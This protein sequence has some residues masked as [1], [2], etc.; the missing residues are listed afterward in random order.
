MCP[1]KIH[2]GTPE[3]PNVGIVLQFSETQQLLASVGELDLTECVVA[4]T[5][6]TRRVKNGDLSDQEAIL[7]AQVVALNAIFTQ[8]AH[9]T[10]QTNRRNVEHV[11]PQRS[12]AGTHWERATGPRSA[13]GKARSARNAYR[14]GYRQTWLEVVRLLNAELRADRELLKRISG[15]MMYK[16]LIRSAVSGGSCRS[17]GRNSARDGD[18]FREGRHIP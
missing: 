7:T 2:G 14:G 10:S 5:M 1:A 11:R 15:H 17:F 12:G 6:A 13:E 18:R 3:K 8:L 16:S 4:L 9:L